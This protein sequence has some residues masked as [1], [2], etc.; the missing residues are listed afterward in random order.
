MF[1]ILFQGAID[2][3]SDKVILNEFL[4]QSD[5]TEEGKVVVRLFHN[6]LHDSESLWWIAIWMLLFNYIG[7]ND[8]DEL[9]GASRDVTTHELFPRTSRTD[10]RF[11]FMTIKD[12][13]SSEL[14]WLPD[15][16][17]AVIKELNT[18]RG[19][20]VTTYKSIERD[21]PA[22]RTALFTDACEA[23][24]RKI[25]ELFKSCSKWSFGV[26]LT[27][28]KMSGFLNPARNDDNASQGA[29]QAP[30]ESA[31]EISEETKAIVDELDQLDLDS[32]TGPEILPA[33]DRSRYAIS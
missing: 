4:F 6:R 21:L 10:L 26:Q 33:L 31:P 27:P 8:E 29:T 3:A 12:R 18:M 5:D 32:D 24:E 25:S 16:L 13:F 19:V 22:L 11:L 7:D 23:E 17:K 14:T 28:C 20:I 1:L 15:K 9:E 2:F 30:V